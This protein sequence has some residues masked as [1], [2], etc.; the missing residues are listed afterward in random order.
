MSMS[1]SAVRVSMS[2]TFP[3]SLSG[4]ACSSGAMPAIMATGVATTMPTAVSVPVA[5]T[6]PAAVATAAA[7]GVGDVVSNDQAVLAE[8]HGLAHPGAHDCDG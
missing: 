2:D 1:M 6:I 4:P 5:A 3:V 8:F 7:S